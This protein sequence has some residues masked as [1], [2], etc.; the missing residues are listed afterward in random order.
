[1]LRFKIYLQILK[2]K[3][4]GIEFVAL[5]EKVSVRQFGQ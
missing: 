3:E 4:K 2:E 5:S 1:M